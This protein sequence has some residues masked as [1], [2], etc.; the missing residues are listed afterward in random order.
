MTTLTRES[1]LAVEDRETVSVPVPEWGQDAIVYVRSLTGAE[2]DAL[3]VGIADARKDGTL[4]LNQRARLVCAFACTST[5]GTLFLP[6]D[7]EVLT[8]KSAIA[9]SRIVDA[10]LQLNAMREEDAQ[11]AVKN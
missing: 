7:I 6:T 9:L 2:R 1:I 4:R 11:E 3:E 10:G 5:G 8:Q